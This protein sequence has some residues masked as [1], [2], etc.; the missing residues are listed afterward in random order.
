MSHWN[1]KFDGADPGPSDDFTLKFTNIDD[2]LAS[3]DQF[4]LVKKYVDDVLTLCRDNEHY[5]VIGN[6]KEILSPDG[7]DFSDKK[8]YALMGVHTG[9]GQS[10]QLGCLLAQFK[11]DS[12][13]LLGLWPDAF[14]EAIRED[15]EILNG[16]LMAFVASPSDWERVDVV[17]P[18]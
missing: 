14:A 5:N 17:I 12:W 13:G 16:F 10:L 3:E 4:V 11:D 18:Q 9:T 6:L 15:K 8:I 2:V 1:V 7:K